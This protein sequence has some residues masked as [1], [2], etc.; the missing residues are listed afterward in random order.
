MRKVF[1]KADRR[2][3]ATVR[4]LVLTVIG[5]KWPSIDSWIKHFIGCI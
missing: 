5:V 1:S 4:D 2:V 3:D